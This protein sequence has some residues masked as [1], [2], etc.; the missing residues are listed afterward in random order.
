[1]IFWGRPIPPPAPQRASQPDLWVASPDG[2]EQPAR[3]LTVSR[4]RQFFGTTPGSIQCG[5]GRTFWS[6]ATVVS[7]GGRRAGDG[8]DAFPFPPQWLTRNE[9]LYTADGHIK[10]WT[11]QGGSSSVIP[12]TATLQ[13]HRPDYPRV[14][15]DLQPQTPQRVLGIVNPAVSPD[16][17]K[18]AFTAVGDLWLLPSGQQPIQLTNDPFVEIDPA[19]SRDGTRLAYA[20]DRGGNMDVWVHDFR[21]GADV[22]ITKEKGPVSGVAWSPDGQDIAF[23][24]NR[25][26]LHVVS[27]AT[28]DRRP[29]STSILPSRE[30]G[31]PTWPADGKRVAVGALF[32]YAA[33]FATGTNQLVLRDVDT[34]SESAATLV[35]HHSAGNRVNNGPVWSPDGLRVTYVTEGRLWVVGVGTNGVPQGDASLLTD[36]L[37]GLPH[38]GRRFAAHRLSHRRW[39]AARVGRRRDA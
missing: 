35:L 23:L 16:G 9:L 19:W 36:D 26:E 15:R 25:S 7:S 10:R 39:T 32:P 2:A 6:A 1:M 20:C 12:F 24:V 14:H 11:A 3:R 22:Q 34:G 21:G 18:I 17:T 33:P 28:G 8:E 5:S 29:P 37:P 4:D 31:R 30:R 13:L 38:L 27:V